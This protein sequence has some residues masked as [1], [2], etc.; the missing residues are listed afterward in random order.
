MQ[1]CFYRSSSIIWQNE[2]FFAEMQGS[3]REYRGSFAADN[4]RQPLV[5]VST[6]RLLLQLAVPGRGPSPPYPH[7]ATTH[8]CRAY[9][10]HHTSTHPHP[11]ASCFKNPPPLSLTWMVSS[12]HFPRLDTVQRRIWEMRN[13]DETKSRAAAAE[14]QCP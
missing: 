7:S 14:G 10:I 11:S 8:A 12:S 5:T 6:S 1:V 13:E 4:H 9:Y 3:L 2:I